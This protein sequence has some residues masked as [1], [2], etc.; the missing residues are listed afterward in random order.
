MTES[1][2]PVE[3]Q[4][5]DVPVL[6]LVARPPV[7]ELGQKDK[8]VFQ[9]QTPDGGLCIRVLMDPDSAVKIGQQLVDAGSNRPSPLLSATSAML[10]RPGAPGWNG[11]PVVPGL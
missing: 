7:T 5:A 9:A 6:A 3:A 11:G 1:S 8:V 2:E 4:V 10:R